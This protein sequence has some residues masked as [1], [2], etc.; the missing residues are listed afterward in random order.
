MSATFPNLSG[1][2]RKPGKSSVSSGQLVVVGETITV[3]SAALTLN[4]ALGVGVTIPKNAEILWTTFDATDM[5][6]G[7]SLTLSL[8]DAASNV[9]LMAANAIGQTGAAPVGPQIAKAGFGYQPTADTVFQ[10]Y[11][12]VAPAGAAAGTVKYCIAFVSP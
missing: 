9:R 1:Q 11:V 3:A 5:D 7:S 2:V 10:P 12:A 4:A 8:G 6:T